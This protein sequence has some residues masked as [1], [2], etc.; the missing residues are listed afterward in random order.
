MTDFGDELPDA[1]RLR[2]AAKGAEAV[3]TNNRKPIRLF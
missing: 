3:E 1:P 2:A